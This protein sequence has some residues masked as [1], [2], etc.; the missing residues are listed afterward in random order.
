MKFDAEEEN[1]EGGDD[2]MWN[3]TYQ[4]TVEAESQK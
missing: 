1:E 3:I 2:E 4:D